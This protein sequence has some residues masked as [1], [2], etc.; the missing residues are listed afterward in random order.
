MSYPDNC[1]AGFYCDGET[2]FVDSTEF[3]SEYFWDPYSKLSTYRVAASDVHINMVGAWAYFNTILYGHN[4]QPAIGVQK[5]YLISYYVNLVK[6][7]NS[8]D[9][10]MFGVTPEKFLKNKNSADK[11]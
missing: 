6:W 8:V 1:P 2:T 3:N 5:G 9:N 7:E 4:L 10:P 11:S